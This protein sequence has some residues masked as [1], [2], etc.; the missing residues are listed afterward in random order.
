MS[1]IIEGKYKVIKKLGEGSFGKIF[2]CINNNTNE[3]VAVKIEEDN[4]T[5]VLSN[6]NI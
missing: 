2:S 1:V 6:I 3:E 5:S 4:K